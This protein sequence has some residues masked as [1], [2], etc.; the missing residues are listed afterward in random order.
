MGSG[1]RSAMRQLRAV[2]LWFCGGMALLVVSAVAFLALA[3]D[4]FYRRTG[5][6]LLES[7]LDRE[8]R[9]EGTF[10]VTLGLE[11]TL[12][13]TDISVANAPWAEKAEMARVERLEVQ[14]AL[15]P[16]FSGVVVIPRLVV[17]GATVDLEIAADGRGNWESA[18][19]ESGDRKDL[20]YSA[21]QGSL[22]SKMSRSAIR[23]GAVARTPTSSWRA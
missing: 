12:V 18:I 13:V 8:V 9:L 19:P 11:P 4:D 23:I 7:V 14:V 15:I 21:D 20:F 17:G 2:L 10:A 16:L 1:S 6:Y 5:G 3:G 22:R